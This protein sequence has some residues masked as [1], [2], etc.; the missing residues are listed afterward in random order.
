L[1]Q[2]S[3]R[4]FEFFAGLTRPVKRGGER[5]G[6]CVGR[7]E[8]GAEQA[9]CLG[10]ESRNPRSGFDH[11]NATRQALQNVAQAFADAVVLFQ[12]GRQVAVG[13]FQFLAEVRHLPLQLPIGTLERT[14]RLGE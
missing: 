12:T 8:A 1:F 10:I 3:E 11:Q 7:L 5:D 2:T 4:Q 6:Q 13:D 14:R 9:T